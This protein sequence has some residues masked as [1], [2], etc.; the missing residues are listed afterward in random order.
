MIN[1]REEI[2]MHKNGCICWTQD[3]SY[4]AVFGD[5]IFINKLP[6]FNKISKKFNKSKDSNEK[7]N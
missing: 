1:Q 6:V 7:D 4:N 5:T 2:I 3:T